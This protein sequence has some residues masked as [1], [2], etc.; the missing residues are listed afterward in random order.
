MH[1]IDRRIGRTNYEERNTGS[2]GGIL[3]RRVHDTVLSFVLRLVMLLLLFFFFLF[4]H[5]IDRFVFW[6]MVNVG[7]TLFIIRKKNIYIY[8]TRLKYHSDKLLR[9]DWKTLCFVT[10]GYIG[11][12]II[13]WQKNF[14]I[15]Y[16]MTLC[17]D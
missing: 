14:K 13:N 3:S 4:S 1:R 2:R 6:S 17:F 9:K 7:E 16:I 5:L 8:K 10:M 11:K 15:T 12:V